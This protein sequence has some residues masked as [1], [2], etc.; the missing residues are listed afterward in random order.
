M[1]DIETD[2]QDWVDYIKEI[3]PLGHGHYNIIAEQSQYGITMRVT[4][5]NVMFAT[6]ELVRRMTNDNMS[7]DMTMI[8]YGKDD[9][10]Y[11]VEFIMENN[12]EEDYE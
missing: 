12:E 5:Y 11:V 1:F 7:Q 6:S 8:V 2:I 3:I 9:K 4:F 10:L